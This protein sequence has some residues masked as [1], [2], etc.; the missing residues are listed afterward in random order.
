VGEGS[1]HYI[2]WEKNKFN[3]SSY[4]TYERKKK[5]EIKTK[6]TIT[7]I[8]TSPA[9]GG[10]TSTVSI[11]SGFFGSQATAALQVIGCKYTSFVIN[12]L[13]NKYIQIHYKI[14]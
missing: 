12:F 7:L 5:Y 10:A 4:K 3:G 11:E 8:L 6:C 1:G 14:K 2:G 9:L 13:C